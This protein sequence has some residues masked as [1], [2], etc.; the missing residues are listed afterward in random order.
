MKINDCLTYSGETK[1]NSK[2][3][4]INGKEYK[5]EK[6]LFCQSRG[7]EYLLSDDKNQNCR[8]CAAYSKG[9]KVYTSGEHLEFK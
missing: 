9:V 8:V 2:T 5:I 1:F 3:V 7:F 6:L 4:L